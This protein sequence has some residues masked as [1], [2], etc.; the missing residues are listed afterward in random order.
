MFNLCFSVAQSGRNPD[1]APN[2]AYIHQNTDRKIYLFLTLVEWAGFAMV[3]NGFMG[4][5]CGLWTK[6]FSC[7]ELIEFDRKDTNINPAG[8][9]IMTDMVDSP[10]PPQ[11]QAYSG[12]GYLCGNKN[13]RRAEPRSLPTPLKDMAA[14]IALEAGPAPNVAGRQTGSPGPARPWQSRWRECSWSPRCPPR[15]PRYPQWSPRAAP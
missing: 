14:V 2:A 15:S 8:R 4:E 13:I 11:G 7:P 3:K 5:R 1:S 6:P 12:S 9:I 10:P